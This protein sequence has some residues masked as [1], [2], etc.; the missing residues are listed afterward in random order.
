MDGETPDRS[1]APTPRARRASCV[2]L[3]RDGG[4]GL[5][6]LLL[7]RSPRARVMAGVW[8]F[9]GGTIDAADGQG[10][11]ADRAAAV[12]E[13]AEEAAIH[14]VDPGTL[15]RFSRW[16]TPAGL[17]AR[18]DTRFFLARLPDDG[19]QAR[20][21]GCECVEHRWLTAQAA[22]DAH[23]DGRILLVLPTIRLLEELRSFGSVDAVF[24]HVRAREL[25]ATA[26]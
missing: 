23:A 26:E 16:I 21:D 14:G 20:V 8:V 22:L 17:P 2:I 10:D 15:A 5:E 12:R 25:R 13:L 18:F 9:P 4:S 19:Q 3:M 24:D 11:R 7:K 1:E 6:L